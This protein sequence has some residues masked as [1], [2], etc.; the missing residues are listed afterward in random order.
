MT[1]T[2]SP[3]TTADALPLRSS[4]HAVTGVA[5]MR[6]RHPAQADGSTHTAVP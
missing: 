3:F 1:V 2:S 4:R 6:L 5:P